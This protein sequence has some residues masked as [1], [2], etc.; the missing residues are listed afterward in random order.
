MAAVLDKRTPMQSIGY[1]EEFFDQRAPIA[2]PA[3]CHAPHSKFELHS[4][5]ELSP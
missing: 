4:N 5:F 2:R 3:F 1:G